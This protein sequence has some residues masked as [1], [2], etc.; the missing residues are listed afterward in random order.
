MRRD[1]PARPADGV[2]VVDSMLAGETGRNGVFLVA[3]ARPV[4]VEAGTAVG[5]GRVA[6]ALA[7]TGVGPRE[8]SAIVVTH[9]HLDHAGGAGE[10]TRRFPAATVWAHP[11]GAR[12]LADPARLVASARRAHGP[13]LDSVYGTPVPVDPARIRVL[14]DG[15]GVPVG[16]GRRL[17]AVHTP[18]HA[19]HHLALLDTGT[20]TLFAGDAAGVRIAGMRVPRPA[21]PPP[22]FDAV[23]AAASLRRMAGL[24]PD[25]LVL[26]HFGAVP[27][28]VGY[29]AELTGRLWR[30]CA[31]AERVVAAGGGA[32]AVEAEL[33]R[34][35]A[36][37]E[38]LPL[39]EPVRFAATGGYRPNAAGLYRW[40][41]ARIPAGGG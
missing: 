16:G 12:H 3:G 25:R 29:L 33:L 14:A 40:A 19:P 24:R 8:L 26:T 21:T 18:G 32:A 2:L 20:G 9:V 5:A 11:A 1:G 35:F 27:E 22:S 30:W 6:A 39:D 38:G 36:A 28:P 15:D 31:A 13:L 34:R 37:E 7:A 10:L 4:L 41:S 23:A 17:V